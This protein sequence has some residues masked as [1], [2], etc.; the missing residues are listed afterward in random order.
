[1]KNSIRIISITLLTLLSFTLVPSTVQAHA[2]TNFDMKTANASTVTA[3]SI[4][5]NF[6]KVGAGD[7]LQGQGKTIMELSEATGI[8]AAFF[9]AKMMNESDWGRPSI[10]GQYFN[11]GNMF[12]VSGDAG[13]YVFMQNGVDRE[14]AAFSTPETGLKATMELLNKYY[15]K[16]INGSKPLKTLGEAL[17]KY[18][19]ESDNNSHDDI[20]NN[21]QSIAKG[22]GQDL[23]TGGSI[24]VGTGNYE[25]DE[26]TESG[27]KVG[28]LIDPMIEFENVEYV[29]QAEYNKGLQSATGM[30]STMVV[31]F[32]QFARNIFEKSKVVT[33]FVMTALIAYMFLS[34]GLVLIGYNGLFGG[35]D[36][37][38]KASDLIL[39]EGIEYN[40]KGLF[41]LFGR[42]L[43]GLVIMAL[44]I[45]GVYVLGFVVI[46]EAVL[47]F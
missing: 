29:N 30:G 25:S 22:F 9:T 24:N 47:Y 39:G 26:L 11:Y 7:S 13:K 44:V 36:M 1:M 38:T 20:M 16:G 23:A 28:E 4:D 2:L 46:Y 6:K 14:G 10:Y 45:S 5:A 37:V 21:I 19:P 18:A 43:I 41:K 12:S 8:N 33:A 17:T 27:K 32:T 3:E 35:N 15:T 40:R 31:G 42:T 34:I